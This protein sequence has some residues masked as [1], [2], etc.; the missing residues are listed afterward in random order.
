MVVE[1]E[2]NGHG[3]PEKHLSEIFDP[4]F[5]TKPAGRGTGLGLSISFGIMQEHQGAIQ[6][7]S[8]EGRGAKFILDFPVYGGAEKNSSVTKPQTLNE[9]RR[10]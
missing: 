7:K 2:D 3:V 5:T 4:F 6:V 10:A 8:E 1:V 9:A